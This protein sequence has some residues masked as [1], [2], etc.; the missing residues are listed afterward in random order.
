MSR[1]SGAIA[2]RQAGAAALTLLSGPDMAGHAVA[3]IATAGGAGVNVRLASGKLADL[4]EA[5]KDCGISGGA[6]IGCATR[7]DEASGS[8]LAG[9]PHRVGEVTLVFAGTITNRP[10]FR[11]NCEDIRD[12]SSGTAAGAVARLIAAEVSDGATPL[13]ALQRVHAALRGNYAIAAIF[14]DAPGMVHLACGGHPL[15]VGYGQEDRDGYSD[16]FIGSSL[17]ALSGLS[18]RIAR[19][20]DGDVAVVSRFGTLFFDAMGRDV[21]R[22]AEVVARDRDASSSDRLSGRRLRDIHEQPEVLGRL[23]GA[24]RSSASLMPLLH[25]MPSR[26]SVWVDRVLLIACGSSHNACLAARHWFESWAGVQADV[27]LASEYRYR[28]PILSGRELAIFVSRSDEAADVLAALA[29]VRQRVATCVALVNSPTSSLAEEC[30]VFFPLHAGAEGG[31]GPAKTFAAQL[32]SLAALSLNLGRDRGWLSAERYEALSAELMSVPRKVADTLQCE[33][34]IRRRAEGLSRH[35]RILVVGRGVCHA[36]ALEAARHFRD[37][38]YASA[39]GYAAGDVRDCAAAGLGGDVACIVLAPS[40]PLFRASMSSYLELEGCGGETLLISDTRLEHVPGALVIPR[41]P[42]LLSCF[43]ML[44][45]LQL[46]A[47]YAAEAARRA[48][49]A[50]SSATVAATAS[51]EGVACVELASGLRAAGTGF[52]Q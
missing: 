35:A 7:P 33:R 42:E 14:D 43:T 36:A 19:L 10:D 24:W 27:E 8:V 15:A 9:A 50:E 12:L 6:A 49:P 5:D 25:D 40:G 32:F 37:A 31:A 13:Q 3:G 47:H 21:E 2:R 41:G 46:L 44:A 23:A 51:P 52:S 29:Q 28:E 17:G 48:G 38:G 45:A 26:E 39:E 22:P 20:E 1:I 18:S 11:R 34:D 16:M 30:G 4:R